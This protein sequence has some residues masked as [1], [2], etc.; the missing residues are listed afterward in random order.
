MGYETRLVDRYIDAICLQAARRYFYPTIV[1]KA[2]QLPLQDVFTRLLQLVNE[3]VLILQWELRCPNYDCADSVEIFDEPPMAGQCATC[4][5]GHE[6]KVD[7]SV[8][9]PILKIH[10]EYREFIR[11]EAKKKDQTSHAFNEAR[12]HNSG[13]SLETLLQLPGV[14]TALENFLGNSSIRQYIT[15]YGGYTVTQNNNSN[16]RIISDSFNGGNF[17]GN[18]NLGDN[19]TQTATWGTTEVSKFEEL[20]QT[21]KNHP[22]I[23]DEDKNDA[24]EILDDLRAKKESGVLRPTILKKMWDMLPSIVRGL[25]V[26]GE[27]FA[28]L[29]GA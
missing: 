22:D 1:Q 16:N 21:I 20:I 9:F 28:I 14:V 17:Q 6:F 27:V 10:P 2:V 13:V 18:V 12:P 5:Y 11:Q 26:A 7:A 23:S 19:V 3:D 4:N 8:I 24:I 15:I 25:T 29:H